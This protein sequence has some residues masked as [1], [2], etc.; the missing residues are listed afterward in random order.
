MYVHP[1]DT[2]RELVQNAADSIRKAEEGSF[3]KRGAGRIEIELGHNSRSVVIRDNGTGIPTEEVGERLID[4]GMSDKDIEHDAGFR[5]IGRLAGIAFCDALKFRTSARG[6]NKV[7]VLEFDC[8][9]IRK[10]ISPA[11]RRILEM[12]DVLAKYVTE[13]TEQ[14]K[15]VDHFLEVTLAGIN[16]SATEFLDIEDVELY[17]QQVAPVDFDPQDFLFTSK[18]QSWVRAHKL[19]L[20]TVSV[21]VTTPEMRRQVFKPYRNSY[22]TSNQR[23]GQVDV[24]IRDVA[25]FLD[26]KTAQ[27]QFWIWW[28]VTDLPGTVGDDRVAGFRFRKNNIALGEP[29]RVADLFAEKK[30]PT[31]RR[32]NAWYVGEI[33]VL[34]PGAIPNARRDG[35][36][37]TGTWPRIRGK[38]L[39]FIAER[40]ADIQ[41]ASSAR[42]APAVKL[43]KQATEVI[44][45]VETSTTHGLASVQ[46]RDKLLADIQ[47]AKAKIESRLKGRS[48]ESDGRELKP[49]VRKLERAET[50]L[51]DDKHFVAKKVCS[52]L[53]RKQR[54]LLQ[55]VTEIIHLVL[56]QQGCKRSRECESAIRT[57]IMEKFGAS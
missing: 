39:P 35:F 17:L 45:A 51:Q 54:Q 53:D 3:I 14:A 29:D 26:D 49:L 43:T 12:A 37:N 33:H 46:E 56:E 30:A 41:R 38:L 31:N 28:G 52:S 42:N 19:E 1:L 7:T 18:I 4:V 24:E 15:P 6:E 57:A 21:V 25:F 50:Q 5:G 13:S 11:N 27:A 8:V 22:R 9:G 2:V 48:G 40:A 32:F 20:P 44:G 47:E 10:A 23:G 16:D 36:E 34:C 55:E